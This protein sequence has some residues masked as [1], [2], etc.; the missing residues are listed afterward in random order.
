MSKGWVQLITSPYEAPILFEHKKGKGPPY[1][2]IL[3]GIK[4]I[5]KIGQLSI[6]SDQRFTWQT[7]LG[8]LPEQYIGEKLTLALVFLLPDF[9]WI[10]VI[11]LDASAIE[12]G[13]VLSLDSGGIFK[14][15]AYLSKKEQ[16]TKSNYY[17]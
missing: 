5:N 6:T 10:Y 16:P 1:V 15:V 11:K 3:L 12:T 17:I 2:H 14:L 13:E 4:Q 9:T 7:Y 8:K